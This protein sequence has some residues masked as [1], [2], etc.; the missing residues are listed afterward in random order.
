MGAVRPV[1]GAGLASWSAVDEIDE[2]VRS[3]LGRGSGI[4]IGNWW[5]GGEQPVQHD[6]ASL[7]VER[8]ST[9]TMPSR[10]REA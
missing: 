5:R 9:L 2:C 6:L 3:S 8:A 7:W 4:A 1:P 10:V